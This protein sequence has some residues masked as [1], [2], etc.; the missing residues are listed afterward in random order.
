MDDSAQI[1]T[2]QPPVNPAD[3][4]AQLTKD[5]LPT[6][7]EEVK[8]FEASAGSAQGRHFKE[9]LEAIAQRIGSLE[10]SGPVEKRVTDVEEVPTNVETEKT[11]EIQGYIE[12][13]EKEAELTSSVTDDY[14]NQVLL[15]SATSQNPI[16]TL[17][18]TEEQTKLGLH[19]KVW[20][21][22][23]W[24]AIWCLRQTKLSPGRVKYKA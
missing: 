19:H 9:Q 23:T 14:T 18:L 2:S 20:E 21:A 10:S 8:Q 16:I 1:P 4:L 3:D 5:P 7:S 15:G 24:L 22:I 11:H 12:T 13:V 6:F 17:P